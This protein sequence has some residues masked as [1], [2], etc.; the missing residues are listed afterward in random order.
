[1][2]FWNTNKNHFL[3]ENFFEPDYENYPNQK[4]IIGKMNVRVNPGD[5]LYIPQ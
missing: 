1:M 5:M 2:T 3:Y 4:Y